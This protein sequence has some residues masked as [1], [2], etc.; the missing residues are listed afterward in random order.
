[1]SEFSENYN[2]NLNNETFE[3]AEVSAPEGVYDELFSKA[4]MEKYSETKALKKT[5][6]LSGIS[7]SLVF[8]ISVLLGVIVG[9]L[10][11][12]SRN[13]FSD[14]AM[15]QAVQ[16]VFSLFSFT[17]PFILCF[18]IGGACISELMS[19]SRVDKKLGLPLFFLGLSCCSFANVGNAYISSFFKAM[20]IDYGIG[21]FNF[22]KGIFGFLLSAIAIAVVPALVEEF[23]LRGVVMGALRKYGDS[24]ALITSS[25]CF[26]VMHGNFEQM[27]FAF[28][29]GLFLG[30]TVIKTG[31]MRVAILLHFTN[32]FVS[33]VFSYFPAS[34]PMEI[35]NLTYI[36]YLII[37]LLVGVVFLL[38]TKTQLFTIDNKAGILSEKEKYKAFFLSG[39]VIVF[40]VINLIQ[41]VS[42]IFL[43]I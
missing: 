21:E 4:E 9:I 12:F 31:S 38:T 19:F 32:N 42:Y 5:A 27:P 41:A 40:L 36:F 13:L 39:G 14:A 37:T 11:V 10:A 17:L 1:M 25:I 2:E 29:V 23:A 22:P 34:V 3:G 20:G 26:A 43:N 6:N 18:K 16:A 30:F 28:M 15:S 33:V 35:Q 24:F 7:L 8:G